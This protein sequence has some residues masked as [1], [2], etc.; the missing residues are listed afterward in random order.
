MLMIFSAGPLPASFPT[1]VFCLFYKQLTSKKLLMT[2]KP[3]ALVTEATAM[4]T[5]PKL[6]TT[7]QK[8]SLAAQ[9]KNG[10]ENNFRKN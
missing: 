10:C 8:I 4:S 5:M 1:L 7:D 9:D 6:M 3:G 2:S